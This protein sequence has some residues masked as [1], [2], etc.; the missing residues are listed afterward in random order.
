[1]STRQLAP[2]LRQLAPSLRPPAVIVALLM[3]LGSCTSA[4]QAASDASGTGGTSTAVT[5]AGS[6]TSATSAAPSADRPFPCEET[7]IEIDA[8]TQGAVADI[9]GDDALDNAFMAQAGGVWNLVVLLGTGEILQRPLAGTNDLDQPQVVGGA[10]LD[11]D[12][13]DELA[14]V[15]GYGAY[16]AL[17]GFVRVRG[18]DLV[19]LRFDDGEPAIFA[20]GASAGG[21]ETLLCNGDGTIERFFFNLMPASEG[22]EQ[23]YDVGYQPFRIEGDVIVGEPG[24]GVALS[25]TEVEALD[26]FDC[27][28]IEIQL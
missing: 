8:Q 25:A 23:T 11:G 4:D 5:T 28:G 17:V 27:L 24:E 12:G 15:M 16:V 22:D 21:G 7:Q 20:T 1:M 10:D 26:L 19:Q 6:G 9:D 18:C 3:F 13:F 14:V 2:S